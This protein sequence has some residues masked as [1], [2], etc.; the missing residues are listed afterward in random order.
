MNGWPLGAT[1]E[2]GWFRQGVAALGMSAAGGYSVFSGS[3]F[4]GSLRGGGRAPV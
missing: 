4:G 3:P 1:R 2:A